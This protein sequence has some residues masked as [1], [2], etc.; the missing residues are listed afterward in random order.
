MP[1]PERPDPHQKHPRRHHDPFPGFP[2]DSDVTREADV[3]LPRIHTR[4]VGAVAAGGA[5]GGLARWA[6]A[7]A[8]PHDPGRFP[9]DTLL[10]NVVGCFLIGVLMVLVVEQWP[11]R[12]LVRPF[13]GTG[14][15][16]GFTTFSTYVVDTRGLLAADRPALA[17][18]YVA[19]TLIV[20][21]LAVVT[22]LRLT[23]RFVR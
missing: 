16:G 10:V 15:L 12:L 6:V 8:L 1:A 3:P 13:F 19:G 21:L 11:E 4:V 23:E 7:E 18:A 9:W 20:G 14:V 5:L 17:T 22:G 2:V